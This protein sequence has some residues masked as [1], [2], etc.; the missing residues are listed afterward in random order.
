[1]ERHGVTVG[2]FSFASN[3]ATEEEAM[4]AVLERRSVETGELS[5]WGPLTYTLGDTCTGRFSRLNAPRNPNFTHF[6]I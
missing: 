1:M 2:T 3:E 6:P 4:Y 5:K